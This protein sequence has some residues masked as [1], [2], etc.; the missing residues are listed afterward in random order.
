MNNNLFNRTMIYFLLNNHTI[1]VINK[2]QDACASI[3]SYWRS[4][5][6]YSLSTVKYY[7][8]NF[9][10]KFSILFKKRLN[11]LSNS[12]FITFSKLHDFKTN[13][14]KFNLSKN[15]TK[16][17]P[18]KLQSLTKYLNITK[19]ETQ[20]NTVIQPRL[21][22]PNLWLYYH[23]NDTN[24][25]KWSYSF[26]PPKQIPQTQLTKSY[27]FLIKIINTLNKCDRLYLMIYFFEVLILILTL[28]LITKKIILIKRNRKNKKIFL[29]QLNSI[30]IDMDI[31]FINFFK[32]P[33][34]YDDDIFQ[35]TGDIEEDKKNPS[36]FSYSY[37]DI[38]YPKKYKNMEE[39][40]NESKKMYSIPKEFKSCLGGHN[41]M[42]IGSAIKYNDTTILH[43]PIDLGLYRNKSCKS[44]FN[45]VK[46]GK[47]TMSPLSV[48]SP[49]KTLLQNNTKKPISV[50]IP[51]NTVLDSN[52][53]DRYPLVTTEAAKITLPPKGSANATLKHKPL[54]W[55][56]EQIRLY[57]KEI[58][59]CSNC[60]E[61]CIKPHHLC[62]CT[63]NGKGCCHNGGIPYKYSGKY[64]MTPFI[65]LDQSQQQNYHNA[66]ERQNTN[67]EKN[68][69]EEYC[70][71][72]QSCDIWNKELR[73]RKIK[74]V[75]IAKR[76]LN[77]MK[78]FYKN[79]FYF[80]V[81]ESVV[82]ET[83]DGK[84]YNIEKMQP[85]NTYK[86]G[87]IDTRSCNL[88]GN[89][90]E[91]PNENYTIDK[92]ARSN[93]RDISDYN[94]KGE[95]IYKRLQKNKKYNVYKDNCQEFATSLIP[96]AKFEKRTSGL[97]LMTGGLF[98]GLNH[99]MY[100]VD[101]NSND[102]IDHY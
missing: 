41:L 91:F 8:S 26:I 99:W 19:K 64:V 54:E 1:W 27:P 67:T 16:S 63:R 20:I 44:L 40:K 18:K 79:E 34:G 82:V 88:N 4:I 95:I 85:D 35:S 50:I 39:M 61:W 31:D 65:H 30:F 9:T 92:R 70:A 14:F 97:L 47:V 53:I 3:K 45:L 46:T 77:S 62:H 22:T 12:S 43:C 57:Q 76:P 60:G 42:V 78:E 36:V 38:H 52:S 71:V 72:Q 37:S 86:N 74:R 100:I 98:E 101:E 93:W 13:I 29:E 23:L 90:V 2:S 10:E 49:A 33:D 73:D 102:D 94:I 6:N 11:F 80:A 28:L 58:W 89:I 66:S 15:I 25:I 83:E 5:Q 87:R 55:L 7:S 81:H 75:A 96:E 51:K 24:F 59:S 48:N 84:Y 32:C 56:N 17:F 21:S 69:E 68:N